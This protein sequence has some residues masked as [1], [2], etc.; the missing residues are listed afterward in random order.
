MTATATSLKKT[1]GFP[2]MIDI[3]PEGGPTSD[4]LYIKHQVVTQ[5]EIN[6]ERVRS[7]W[8]GS[9]WMN[10]GTEPGTYCVLC[11]GRGYAD[12]WMSDTWFERFTNYKVLQQARGDVLLAGLGI[13]MLA[14]ALC[15]K[16]EVT[17]VT[18]LELQQGVIDLVEPHIRH[19]KLRV[20]RADAKSAPFKGRLFDTIYL[21]IWA[22]INSDMWIDMK[23]ML[24]EYR[25]LARKGAFVSAWLKSYTQSLYRD[26]RRRGWY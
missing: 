15:A 11:I 13:G 19:P 5:E 25:K 16:P 12:I 9:A 21:D 26:E 1:Y 18:V 2:I 20:I 24:V 4:G 22:G 17:S 7:V 10:T 14:V 6:L 3:I 8:S 23:P